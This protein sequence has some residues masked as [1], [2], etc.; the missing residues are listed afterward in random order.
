MS[1]LRSVTATVNTVCKKLRVEDKGRCFRVKELRKLYKKLKKISLKSQ[2]SLKT[3]KMST[4]WERNCQDRPRGAVVGGG[5]EERPAE[6][7]GPPR[8]HPRHERHLRGRAQPAG[9]T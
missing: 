9:Q 1:L 3:L 4:E 6:D 5:G 2:N 7:G 8:G